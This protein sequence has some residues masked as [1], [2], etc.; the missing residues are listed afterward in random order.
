MSGKGGTSPATLETLASRPSS[1]NTGKGECFRN[2]PTKAGQTG[3]VAMPPAEPSAQ[4]LSES[5]LVSSDSEGATP[6]PDVS[7]T[8]VASERASGMS[9]GFLLGLL[10]AVG[11][12][13]VVAFILSTGDGEKTEVGESKG[14][15]VAGLV[16][17]LPANAGIGISPIHMPEKKAFADAQPLQAS[18]ASPPTDATAAIAAVSVGAGVTKSRGDSRSKAHPNTTKNSRLPKEVEDAL[19]AADKLLRSGRFLQS[20][21]AL[22]KVPRAAKTPRGFAT[23]V[24]SYCGE[25]NFG[26]AT[27]WFAR[28]A[29]SDRRRVRKYCK[30]K[31][32]IEL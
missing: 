12:V 7:V 14:G 5:A 28:V 9:M 18:D 27:D 24:M 26:A 15:L 30:T 10:V 6:K 1:R 25:H 8:Q 31:H 16:T 4:P 29:R 3:P 23:T 13:A 32:G 19:A 22:G 11:G 17:P 21:K 20:R 2:A